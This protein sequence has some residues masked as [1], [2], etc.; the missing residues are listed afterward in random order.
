L[1]DSDVEHDEEE[2]EDDEDEDDDE[3][4]DGGAAAAVDNNVDD[5]EGAEATF[6][7]FTPALTIPAISRCP[8]STSTSAI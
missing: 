7:S 5:G 4:G 2:E 8:D 3:D 6:T 1:H